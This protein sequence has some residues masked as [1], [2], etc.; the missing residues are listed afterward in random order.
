M[1]R[2]QAPDGQPIDFPD[3]MKDQEIE[4][5]MKNLYPSKPPTAWDAIKSYGKEVLHNVPH[6]AFNL[7]VK[8][9]GPQGSDFQPNPNAGLPGKEGL[10][11]DY[12]LGPSAWDTIKGIVKNPAEAFK[13][14]PLGMAAAVRGAVEFG[15]GVVQSPSAVAGAFKK[16]PIP[17]LLE[18][19]PTNPSVKKL[20]EVMNPAKAAVPRFQEAAQTAIPAMKEFEGPGDQI[21]MKNWK[22]AEQLAEAKRN[23][24]VDSFITPARQRGVMLD[25]GVITKEMMD[26]IPKS[27]ATDPNYAAQ[28]KTAVA[29]AQSYNH[30][31]DIDSN[32]DSIANLNRQLTPF[33]RASPDKQ[34]DLQASGELGQLEAEARG[35]RQALAQG[36]DPEHGGQQF[37]QLRQEQSNLITFRQHA[38]GLEDTLEKQYTPTGL[39]QLGKKISDVASIY[40]GNYGDLLTKNMRQMPELNQQFTDAF[41]N[42]DGPDLPKTPTGTPNQTPEEVATNP[43]YKQLPPAT[44]RLGTTD[45]SEVRVTTGKPLEQSEPVTLHIQ[46]GRQLPLQ[47]QIKAP[48]PIRGGSI[49]Y[50]WGDI[51]ADPKTIAEGEDV[52]ASPDSWKQQLGITK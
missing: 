21:T 18:S 20:T 30:P 51:L 15:R 50:S 25:G 37:E 44:T 33:Y 6:S 34:F 29:R 11:P 46:E 41:K 47:S 39:Q 10:E 13:Q 23:Q 35:R 19:E 36:V 49:P 28:Y 5:A 8:G 2:V 24:A 38:Q 48:A 52:L 27:W 14:D 4:A 22:N 12:I 3:S 32:M 40:H 9:F 45:P 26:A 7:Y 43:K 31:I 42:W 17:T 16:N 1:P